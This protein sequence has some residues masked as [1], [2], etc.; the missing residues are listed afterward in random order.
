MSVHCTLYRA[1]AAGGQLV[2]RLE[3]DLDLLTGHLPLYLVGEV[4]GQHR[5]LATPPRTAI[6][7]KVPA[8]LLLHT[9]SQSFYQ[10]MY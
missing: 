10:Y 1:A 4:R 8:S 2:E 6:S 7:T 5:V 3:L 9:N